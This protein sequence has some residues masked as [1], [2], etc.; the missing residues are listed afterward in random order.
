MSE[1]LMASLF[2]SELVK[3]KQMRALQAST[4]MIV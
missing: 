2:A 4:S 3:R 1:M